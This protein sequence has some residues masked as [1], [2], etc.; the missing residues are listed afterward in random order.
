MGVLFL[1]E[2]AEFRRS[3]LEALRQ[4]LED[5]VVTISR[6]QGKAT[7]PARPLLVGAMNPCSCGFRGDGT[8]RCLCTPERVRSYRARLS[9]PLLDRIDIHVVL[10]PVSVN[11]LLNGERGESTGVVR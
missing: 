5:G 3:G 10:P 7:F 1:D 11:A 8:G 9:G 4:P 6:A 2:L